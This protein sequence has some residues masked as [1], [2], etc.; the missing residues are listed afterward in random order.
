MSASAL[1]EGSCCD[2]T[3]NIKLNFV[4]ERIEK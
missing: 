4:T 3:K 1:G 2:T